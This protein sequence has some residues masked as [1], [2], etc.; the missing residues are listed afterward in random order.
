[1]DEDGKSKPN[2]V[3]VR[4]LRN[5]PVVI[6]GIVGRATWNEEEDRL[7]FVPDVN[8]PGYREAAARDGDWGQWVIENDVQCV[9]HLLVLEIVN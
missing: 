5:S 1:M 6:E 7:W 2:E 4:R 9:G 3:D 8:S